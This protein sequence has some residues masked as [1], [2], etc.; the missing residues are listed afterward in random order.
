MDI[1]DEPAFR[2]DILRR[3][4]VALAEHPVVYPRMNPMMGLEAGRGEG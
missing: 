1:R 4:K 2:T 3:A